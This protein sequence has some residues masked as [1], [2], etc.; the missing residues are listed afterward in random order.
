MD[1][2]LS[3]VPL[4]YVTRAR[5]AVDTLRLEPTQRHLDAAR[6][7]FERL[8][9][10]RLTDKES[11]GI[12]A[13]LD[14]IGKL[15]PYHLSFP[16]PP[17]LQCAVEALRVSLDWAFPLRACAFELPPDTKRK[18]VRICEQNGQPFAT[19]T[20]ACATLGISRGDMNK[21]RAGQAASAGGYTFRSE[22]A[23]R[24]MREHAAPSAARN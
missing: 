20:D 1:N 22:P 13:A 14:W 24:Y 18:H 23:R 2:Q 15:K 21:Y 16:P 8:N 4:G 6:R 5:R 7:A 19:W 10:W 17:A 3:E 12:E 11:E 9:D